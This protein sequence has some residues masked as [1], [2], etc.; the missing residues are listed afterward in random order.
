[1]ILSIYYQTSCDS[2]LYNVMYYKQANSQSYLDDIALLQ[3]YH[4]SD[5][6][7]ALA[8]YPTSNHKRSILTTSVH[9]M[10]VLTAQSSRARVPCPPPVVLS[11]LHHI[12][13]PHCRSPISNRLPLPCHIAY[14]APPMSLACTHNILLHKHHS[15]HKIRPR[16]T[17]HHHLHTADTADNRSQH[18]TDI[19]TSPFTI[20]VLLTYPS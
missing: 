8:I 17:P 11:F 12:S 10:Y 2:R 9:N 5:G 16:G 13:L 18:G 4:T 7:S 6:N 3:D 20:S 15:L 14:P 19:L 1:M